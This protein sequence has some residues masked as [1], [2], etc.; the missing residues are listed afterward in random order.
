MH[1]IHSTV[2]LKQITKLLSRDGLSAFQ[3]Q[4]NCARGGRIS[5]Q[6]AV[7]CLGIHVVKMYSPVQ[8]LPNVL[9][10]RAVVAAPRF[11]ARRSARR[12]CVIGILLRV[13]ASSTFVCSRSVLR[14]CLPRPRPFFCDTSAPQVLHQAQPGQRSVCADQ[15]NLHAPRPN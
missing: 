14:L 1:F 2:T 4:R 5:L 10:H 3:K 11:S 6:D 15:R 9:V 12:A 13:S 8:P 7:Q